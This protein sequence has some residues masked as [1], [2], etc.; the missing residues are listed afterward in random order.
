MTSAKGYR[1]KLNNIIELSAWLDDY[2][3]TSLRH[4]G[5]LYGTLVAHKAVEY[6]DRDRMGITDLPDDVFAV[7]CSD[8]RK[9]LGRS[10]TGIIA[11]DLNCSIKFHLVHDAVLATFTH[12]NDEYLKAWE[13]NKAVVKWGWAADAEPGGIPEQAW[14]VREKYWSKANSRKLG[15]DLQFL[16]VDKPLPDIGWGAIWRYLPSNEQRI[17]VAVEAL[18]ESDPTG[19]MN[20]YSG[21]KL[22]EMVLRSIEQ[23]VNKNSFLKSTRNRMSGAKKIRQDVAAARKPSVAKDIQE[24]IEAKERKPA[25]ASEIDHADII[26]AS[27]NKIFVAVP[28]VGLDP[29][30]RVFVQVS[31]KHVAFSQ[32]GVQYGFVDNVKRSSLDVL[33]TTNQVILIEIEKNFD[34]R[35]LRA[36]H[37]AIVTD[38]SLQDGFG[39][40]INRFKQIANTSMR[41]KELKE[42]EKH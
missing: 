27:D 25:R 18:K 10:A 9:S 3:T 19:L 28:Y 23:E 39:S 6:L 38:I 14:K 11:P 41:E 5:K 30:S 13:A 4:L 20:R 8:V 7:A 17:S 32:N 26:V 37:M 33:K 42:W 2:R 35:L 15:G 31:D 34:E 16:L 22:K 1:L 36:K 29:D 40:A 12:G 21:Q 24:K